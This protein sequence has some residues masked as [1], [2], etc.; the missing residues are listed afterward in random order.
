MF[1]ASAAGVECM[2]GYGLEGRVALFAMGLGRVRV[3]RLGDPGSREELTLTCSCAPMQYLT[4][5]NVPDGPSFVP[6]A[7][8]QFQRMAKQRRAPL[9]TKFTSWNHI[10]LMEISK[11]YNV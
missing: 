7:R 1:V 6:S 5:S 4:E 3:S 2:Y 8:R 10:G 11:T 9:S